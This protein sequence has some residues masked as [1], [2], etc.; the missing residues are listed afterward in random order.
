MKAEFGLKH[1]LA[2]AC[3]LSAFG[4]R[5]KSWLALVFP[6]Y[7]I[8]CGERAEGLDTSLRAPPCL[9]LCASCRAGLKGIQGRR[10]SVCGKE[11]YSELET[12]CSCR[13]KKPACAAVY[14][15]F[16]YRGAAA[17]LLRA[18]KFKQRVSLAAFWAALA[19]QAIDERWPGFAIVPV[20]PRPE[21]IRLRQWDQVE[22]IVVKLHNKGYPIE[23]LL[24][25]RAETQQKTLNRRMRKA[26]AEKAYSVIPAKARLV[27]SKVLILDDVYTTG[28][29]VEA[30]AQALRAQGAIDIAAL[31]IAAD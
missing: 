16:S 15:L 5:L 20:P 23:R 28:A 7:C 17:K 22:A 31:V 13:G 11:L 14:P 12:C 19:A 3:G 8:L 18:Y 21:K 29:T 27:P 10:C 6:H 24:E 2:G 26:N 1:A 9:P 4:E 30:C 25:R